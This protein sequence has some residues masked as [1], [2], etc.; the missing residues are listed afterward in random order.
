MIHIPELRQRMAFREISTILCRSMTTLST[1]TN[2]KAERV[3]N[4]LLQRAPAWCKIQMVAQLI[5][6]IKTLATQVYGPVSKS[7][8]AV[9]TNEPV[10]VT[11]L[12]IH[13]LENR[14]V[15]LREKPFQVGRLANKLSDELRKVGVTLMDMLEELRQLPK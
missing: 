4:E 14:V 8:D 13:A 12:V 5:K 6:T 7:Y 10:Q 3:Q 15:L 11:M 9:M 2:P 1:D